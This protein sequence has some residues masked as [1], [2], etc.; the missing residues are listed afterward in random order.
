M[1]SMLYNEILPQECLLFSFK[2]II[3]YNIK[4]SDEDIVIFIL[5]NNN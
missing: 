1:N 3:W 2:L 4:I 5:G